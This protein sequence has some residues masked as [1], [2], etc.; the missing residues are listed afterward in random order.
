MACCWLRH[1]TL[2]T[3]ECFEVSPTVSFNFVSVSEPSSLLSPFSILHSP[4]LLL[5][6]AQLHVLPPP[7][8]LCSPPPS[9]YHMLVAPLLLEQFS[10]FVISFFFLINNDWIWDDL[11]IIIGTHKSDVSC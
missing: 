7:P 2:L 11:S 10:T 5:C 1:N 3:I 9:P 8:L 4:S 6:V